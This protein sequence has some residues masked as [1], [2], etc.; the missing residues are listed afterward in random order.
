VKFRYMDFSTLDRREQVCRRELEINQPNA[1]QIYLGVVPV[2]READ[3][4]LALDGEG[5]PVEWAVHM[6]RFP[7]D[8]LLREQGPR[9][10]TGRCAWSTRLCEVIAGFHARAPVLRDTGV[11]RAGGEH[12]WQPECLV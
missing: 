3:G 9:G 11:C 12:H 5:E 6:R 1:P 10:A 7:D 2:T 4:A 8:A